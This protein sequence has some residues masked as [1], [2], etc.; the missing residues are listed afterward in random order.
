MNKSSTDSTCSIDWRR[1]ETLRDLARFAAE[2]DVKASDALAWVRSH[3]CDN[4]GD[5]EWREA[6]G[7]MQS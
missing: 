1:R 4:I 2:R 6:N 3:I 7:V 5:D